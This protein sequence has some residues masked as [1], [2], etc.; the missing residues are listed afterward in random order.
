MN[1][2]AERAAM[3]AGSIGKG[4]LLQLKGIYEKSI[5]R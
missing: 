2:G 3:G 5:Y 4:P 1:L